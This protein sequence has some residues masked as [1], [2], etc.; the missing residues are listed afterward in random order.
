MT[1]PERPSRSRTLALLVSLLRWVPAPE[2]ISFS[3]VYDDSLDVQLATLTDFDEWAELL[4]ADVH[5]H[6]VQYKDTVQCSGRVKNWNGWDLNLSV[7]M[8]VHGELL[9]TEE[10]A[11]VLAAVTE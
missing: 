7:C 8:R 6:G 3:A 10:S 5:S 1:A 2:L 9:S 11:E 4:R